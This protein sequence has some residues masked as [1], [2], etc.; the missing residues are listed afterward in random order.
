MGKLCSECHCNLS[1]SQVARHA[2]CCSPTCKKRHDAKAKASRRVNVAGSLQS[3]GGHPPLSTIPTPPLPPFP[4]VHNPQPAD[5]NDVASH[6]ARMALDLGCSVML[7]RQGATC[8]L[9]LNPQVTNGQSGKVDNRSVRH[10]CPTCAQ[11]CGHPLHE[12]NEGCDDWEPRSPDVDTPP[13]CTLADLDR[14]HPAFERRPRDFTAG[15]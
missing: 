4:S 3:S 1:P 12:G 14:D 15:V 5:V 11:P 9:K 13:V 2:V 10:V 7:L 8:T 6:L